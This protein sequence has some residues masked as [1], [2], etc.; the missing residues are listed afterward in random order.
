MI[1][2]AVQEEA[3]ST[4]DTDARFVKVFALATP[5]DRANP[6]PTSWVGQGGRATAQISRKGT[7]V[8][9][10]IDRD[11]SFGDFVTSQLDDLYAAF[12]A[13]DT[14]RTFREDEKGGDSES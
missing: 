11:P 13:R 8:T 9:L 5:R 10:A 14:S 2:R 12:L 3:F 7:S 6:A 4:L 1:E